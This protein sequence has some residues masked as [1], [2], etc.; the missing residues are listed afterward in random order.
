MQFKTFILDPFQEDAVRSIEENH[1]VVVS[2][3]TGTGKTLIAEYVIDKSLKEHRR[4]V[5]TAPIK[6]LSNQKYRDFKEDYGEDAVGILTGDVSINPGAPIL[7]MTTEVYRN[8]LLSQE[9][10][11]DRFSYIIFDEIHF[12]NDPERGVVWEESII[13]SNPNV[14]FL[15][16][17]ATIPNAREFADWI[18]SIQNHPVD[19]VIYTKRAVPLRHYVFDAEWGII[20]GEEYKERLRRSRKQAR[21]HH[22]PHRRFRQEKK[23]SSSSSRHI[24]LVR[25]LTE[26]H[27][28]PSLF[29]VFSRRECQTMARQLATAV[30]LATPQ[31]KAQIMGAFN[32]IIDPEIRTMQSVRLLRRVLE[33][34]IGIHHAGLLPHLKE[35]VEKFFNQGLLKV[36]YCTETFAVGVNMPAKTVCFNSLEKYD[37][38]SFR[39]LFSKEYFQCAGRAGRR[40]IDTLGRS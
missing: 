5:Y 11:M 25:E 39:Y 31:E 36:L 34:G 26:E 21:K 24:D 22:H 20:S 12:I 6:A 38:R 28:L 37:G 32:R 9:P 4:V 17:S 33:N 19:T 1:S 18:S 7:I 16:L 35:V 30:D 14:R 2:A 13:F 27:A 40:G 8:M 3:A 10:D 15:C 23:S 29:F